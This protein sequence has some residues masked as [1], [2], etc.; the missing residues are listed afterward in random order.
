MHHDD[1]LE[2]ALGER[3]ANNARYP[4][5]RRLVQWDGAEEVW[6]WYWVLGLGLD[7]NI[8]HLQR[9]GRG[10]A[11]VVAL[12]V[13]G[14]RSAAATSLS[15]ER[16]GASSLGAAADCRGLLGNTRAPRRASRLRCPGRPHVS[17]SRPNV[18]L[19]LSPDA[20]CSL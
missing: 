16:E 2:V 10:V 14:C 12:V 11:Y 18:F 9:D 4:R 8:P 17:T 5:C 19:P 1:E 3:D 15:G 13:A 6:R 7:I 20:L